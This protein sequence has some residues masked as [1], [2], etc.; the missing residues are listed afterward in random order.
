MSYPNL[1]SEPDY[2]SAMARRLYR[3][4]VV[5]GRIAVPAV[6]GM[7]DEYVKMCDS[8]FKAIGVAFNEAELTQLRDIIEKELATA[9]AASPRSEII[10]T[11]DCPHGLVVNYHVKGEWRT[12]DAEYENWLATR[13]PPFFGT[14]PDALVW[15]LAM[16]ALRPEEF[17]ILDIGAGTARNSLPFAR[18]G[19]P[20]D[21]IELTSKFAEI[22]RDESQRESLNIR[23][24]Q[25]DIFN[26]LID[27][28]NDYQLIILSEVASD[29]RTPEQL[30]KLFMLAAK[31]LA[32]GGCLVLN[33]FLTKTGYALKDS[34]RQL[35]QQF[36]SSIFTRQE[37]DIAA[38]GLP[39]S[40]ISDESVYEYEKANLPAAAWPPT[41]WYEGWVTGQDVYDVEREESPI[42]LRW[43]VY[44]K[45]V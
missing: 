35:G 16:K 36:Y 13:K 21:A 23:V 17:P 30:H 26:D 9:F 27:V 22:I 43:L 41:S 24:I 3:R 11:Y 37:V 14:E 7:I 45:P 31:I 15:K 4:A 1:M 42:E 38:K 39:I 10:I 20:V 33:I 34:A 40:L 12:I 44:Q 28:R 32:P 25:Q 6:P 8:V 2:Q 29:F 5:S 19:H 18:R